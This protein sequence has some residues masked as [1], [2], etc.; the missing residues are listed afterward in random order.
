MEFDHADQHAARTLRMHK[1][2]TAS[3]VAESMTDELAAGLDDLIASVVQ[4]L[5]LKANVVEARAASGKIFLKMRIRAKRTNDF[6]TH[7]TVAFIVVRS[8]VL[9][10][11]LFVP[12]RL[13]SK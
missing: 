8:H 11:D 5:D 10:M 6:E 7:P 3:R 13:N 2:V 9:I 1:G 4:I 12:G